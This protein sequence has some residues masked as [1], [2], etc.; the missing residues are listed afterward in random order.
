MS[1]S[2]WNWL[3]RDKGNKVGLYI[4]II[5][6]YVLNCILLR[7]KYNSFIINHY[8]ISSAEWPW[9]HW[10][11]SIC[12][13]FLFINGEKSFSCN[14]F[15]MPVICIPMKNSRTEARLMFVLIRKCVFFFHNEELDKIRNRFSFKSYSWKMHKFRKK[16]H[17]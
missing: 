11:I 5:S 13:S 15:C 2:D 7:N 4:Y 3:A 1:E 17:S 8:S 6:T 9:I 14:I 10:E 16:L 12:F